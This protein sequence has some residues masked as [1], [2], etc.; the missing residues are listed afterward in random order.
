MRD[1]LVAMIRIAR[2]EVTFAHAYFFPDHG[3]LRAL[4][5]AA[6][7]GVRVRIV[8]PGKSDV[9]RARGGT[10]LLGRML[11]SG[12]EVRERRRRMLHMKA[13][14]IDG[15]AVIA[16]SAN[17]DTLSLF[18]NKEISVNIL[19]PGAAAELRAALEE[20]LSDSDRIRA[21]DWSGRGRLR[22]LVERFAA[23]LRAW[24]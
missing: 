16:G 12:I 2:G 21:E 10:E 13:G 1:A 11:R 9:D 24:Y 8:L 4:R 20:D 15:E 19:D 23:W 7:R 14:I 5:A 3:T 17:L 22:R 6:R 18:R